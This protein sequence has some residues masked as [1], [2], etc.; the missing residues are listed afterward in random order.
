M[1]ERDVFGV[2]IEKSLKEEFTQSV[3]EKG[4][5]TCFVVETLLR[6][7]LAGLKA[8][9]EIEVNKSKTIVINQNFTRTF[10]RGRR[11]LKGPSKDMR[12]EIDVLGEVH[13]TNRY[14]NP[15]GIWV[16]DPEYQE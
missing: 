12:R 7:W 15:P 2:R 10:V 11:F 14:I 5:S 6:A 13:E 3:K 16:Y 9:S 8:P 1:V 4:L